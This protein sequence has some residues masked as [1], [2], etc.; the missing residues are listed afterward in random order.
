MIRLLSLRVAGLINKFRIKL[1]IRKQ[2]SLTRDVVNMPTSHRLQATTKM[3]F[4]YKES[5]AR[6]AIY[7]WCDVIEFLG[8]ELDKQREEF[9]DQ[10]TISKLKQQEHHVD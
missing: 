8:Q 4:K 1:E 10:V 9:G 6:E 5:N 3:R 7:E 2:L